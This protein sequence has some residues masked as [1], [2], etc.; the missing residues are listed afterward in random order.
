MHNGLWSMESECIANAIDETN[1]CKNTTPC[2]PI[3]NALPSTH[4]LNLTHLWNAIWKLKKILLYLVFN[5]LLTS[6]SN[7]PLLLLKHNWFDMCNRKLELWLFSIPSLPSELTLTRSFL[8]IAWWFAVTLDIAVHENLWKVAVSGMLEP[9]CLAPNNHTTFIL[10]IVKLCWAVIEPPNLVSVCR[11]RSLKATIRYVSQSGRWVYVSHTE[12]GNG[13]YITSSIKGAGEKFP[14]WSYCR[15]DNTYNRETQGV[16]Q[17]IPAS[18]LPLYRKT[19]HLSHF[20]GGDQSIYP[21]F[22]C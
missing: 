14:W 5:L 22:Q 2:H 15:W 3:T 18:P 16:A 19:I 20:T 8:F 17:P 9:Q 6:V 4:W 10:H 7:L 1:A 13:T 11:S 12:I 21:S